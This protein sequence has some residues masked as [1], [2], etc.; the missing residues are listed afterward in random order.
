MHR[1]ARLASAARSPLA[2]LATRG[3]HTTGITGLAV[4]PNAKPI[5]LDIY[6]KTLSALEGVPST[7]EYRKTVEA[8]TKERMAVV[9]GTDDLTV[10]ESTI[11]AGQVEQLIQQAQDELGLIPRLVSAR[12]FDAYDGSP[13]EEIY[14]DLKR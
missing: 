12:A 10:I 9:Q 4:E 13:A 11:A 5:L 1:V 7:A 14:A 8:L 3:K 2:S 6:A